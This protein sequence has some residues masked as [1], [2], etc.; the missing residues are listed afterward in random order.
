MKRTDLIAKLKAVEPALSS[1]PI[2]PML[3]QYWFTGESL[4]AYNDQIALAVPLRTTFKGALPAK[5]LPLLEASGFKEME[6]A[7]ADNILAIRRATSN[8]AAIKLAMMAPEFL[9]T[10]PEVGDSLPP[11]KISS[12]VRAIEHCLMSVGTDTSKP[13]YLGVTVMTE[14]NRLSAYSTD[15]NTISRTRIQGVEVPRVI[16]PGEFCRQMVR[17]FNEFQKAH[18]PT[19]GIQSQGE[20]QYALFSIAE[21]TLYGRIIATNSPLNFSAVLSNLIPSGD[22]ELVPIPEQFRGAV[23]RACIVCDHDRGSTT[24]S[25]ADGRMRLRSQTE[26]E[27]VEDVLPIARSHPNLSIKVE[28]HLLKRGAA[29]ETLLIRETC[30]VMAKGSRLYLIACHS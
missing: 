20:E 23:D 13:E 6:M 10:M 12:L 5:L 15:G 21:T 9:F 8:K 29:F 7:A 25:V 4:L 17:L 11:E 3:M 28:P 30:V 19:F 27:D 22:D 18:E 24:I 14:G 1:N 26:G 16:L 2:V